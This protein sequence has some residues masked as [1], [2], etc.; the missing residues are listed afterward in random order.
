MFYMYIFIRFGN[1][2]IYIYLL[3]K[4]NIYELKY[5]IERNQEIIIKMNR[6]NINM[7]ALSETKKVMS[8]IKIT[9]NSSGEQRKQTEL[10][11][12]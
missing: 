10:W 12:A 2:Y 1:L 3:R 6:F 4:L 8:N 11:L 7:Y 5:S 9:F